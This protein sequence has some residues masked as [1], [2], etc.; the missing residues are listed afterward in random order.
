MS[1][2]AKGISVRSGLFL[3]NIDNAAFLE[4]QDW[5]LAY[6][7]TGFQLLL[8]SDRGDLA[9]ADGMLTNIKA[10]LLKANR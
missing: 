9:I 5:P 10:R 2:H 8:V 4:K 3:I 7:C 6:A 1:A